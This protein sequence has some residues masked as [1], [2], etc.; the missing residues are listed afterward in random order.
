MI[1]LDN[2]S[3]TNK[4]PLSVKI[5][6][7]KSLSKKYCANPGRSSH[8]PS[9]NASNVVFET[10][11]LL[12]K[13]FN[14]ESIENI[15]FTSGC[16]EA[17]N[18]AILGTVNKG[19]HIIYETNAHNSVARPVEFLKSRGDITAT[20]VETNCDGKVDPQKIERA[21]TN[22]TYLVIVNHTSNVSG[23]T[24]NINKIGEICKKH[25]I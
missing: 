7:K 12:Q 22:K 11:C 9:L 20:L 3:T 24:S 18:M 10:R 2:A 13:F 15:V 6:V 1:Y 25:S 16:T 14:A 4:K 21:I 17:L 19:G 5:A 8:K 23:A